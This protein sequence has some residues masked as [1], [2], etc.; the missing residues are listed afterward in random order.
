MKK[1]GEIELFLEKETKNY[2]IYNPATEDMLPKRIYLHKK[3]VTQPEKNIKL[4]VT[5]KKGE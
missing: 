3:L 1:L 2:F 5:V 4:T